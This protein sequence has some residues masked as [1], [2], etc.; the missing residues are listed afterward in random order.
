VTIDAAKSMI[1]DPLP[2]TS[3]SCGDEKGIVSGDS[4][5]TLRER[6]GE[7]KNVVELR[8]VTVMTTV[9]GPNLAR[10]DEDLGDAGLVHTAHDGI[11]VFATALIGMEGEGVLVLADRGQVHDINA[12]R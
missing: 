4:D 9:A 12:T 3:E 5:E 10:S 2:C 8:A 1:A 6:R 11:D 7:A